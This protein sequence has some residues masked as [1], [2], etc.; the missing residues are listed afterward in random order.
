MDFHNILKIRTL[1]HLE[2]PSYVASQ[3]SFPLKVNHDPES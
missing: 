1:Q 3:L 2:A